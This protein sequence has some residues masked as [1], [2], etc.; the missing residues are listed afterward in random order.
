MAGAEVVSEVHVSQ[1][2]TEKTRSL[3]VESVTVTLASKDVASLEKKAPNGFAWSTPLKVMAPTTAGFSKP[4]LKFTATLYVP[5]GGA[6]IC[7]IS[8]RASSLW[9]RSP[10][11]VSGWPL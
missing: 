1:E 10:T 5:S 4:A 6:S 3:I 8:T 9:V 2:K 7:Q 11:K